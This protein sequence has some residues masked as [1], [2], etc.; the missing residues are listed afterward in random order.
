[1]TGMASDGTNS[2][3]LNVSHANLHS[4]SSTATQMLGTRHPSVL[5]VQAS[6]TQQMPTMARL[7]M[8]CGH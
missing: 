4:I 6:S 3:P 5:A 2:C 7:L 1:M 8:P